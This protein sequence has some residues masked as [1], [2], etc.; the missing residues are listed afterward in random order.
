[1]GMSREEGGTMK[2]SLG[3]GGIDGGS[4]RREIS[5]SK[6]KDQDRYAARG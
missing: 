2:G 6:D 3:G 4:E 5:S 1:M